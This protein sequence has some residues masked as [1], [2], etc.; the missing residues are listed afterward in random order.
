MV[1]SKLWLNR[2][3]SIVGLN[4]IMG[5]YGTVPAPPPHRP[6]TSPVFV[7]L[8]GQPEYRPTI[9]RPWTLDALPLFALGSRKLDDWLPAT[10]TSCT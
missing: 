2:V 3:S 4:P 5:V 9:V 8:A 7:W 10:T 6:L 1:E